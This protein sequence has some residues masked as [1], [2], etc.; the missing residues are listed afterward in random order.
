[1]LRRAGTASARHVV[2]S[3]GSIERPACNHRA[4]CRPSASSGPW[5]SNNSEIDTFAGF[6]H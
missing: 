4:G 3:S 1:V 5:G 6:G 2:S